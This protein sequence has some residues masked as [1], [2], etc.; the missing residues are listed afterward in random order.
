[1]ALASPFALASTEHAPLKHHTS[2]SKASSLLQVYL[3]DTQGD[4]T[5]LRD[6]GQVMLLDGGSSADAGFIRGY[7]QHLGISHVDYIVALNNLASSI[8]GLTNIL[9]YEPSQYYLIANDVADGYYSSSLMDWLDQHNLYW[10][11]PATD[12]TVSLGSATVSFFTMNPQ[13]PLL[14]TVQDGDQTLVFT[15]SSRVNLSPDLLSQ[16]P[17]RVNFY[18]FLKDDNSFTLPRGLLQVIRPH[19]VIFHNASGV[20]PAQQ[21]LQLKALKLPFV[22]QSRTGAIVV[23][24]DGRSLRYAYSH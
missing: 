4:F 21:L 18:D 16:L 13:G 7:L 20:N 1:M 12:T 2:V 6:Q 24:S 14:V 15:S 11:V 10:Q 3:P 19:F 17:Q 8:G 22:M 9:S 23:T 5:I